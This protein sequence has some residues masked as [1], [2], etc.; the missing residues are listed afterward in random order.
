M[1]EQTNTMYTIHTFLGMDGMSDEGVVSYGDGL[2]TFQRSYRPLIGDIIYIGDRLLDIDAVEIEQIVCVGYDVFHA[3]C[4]EVK[5]DRKHGG[6]YG[7]RD[8]KGS[9]IAHLE[10]QIEAFP[11]RYKKTND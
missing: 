10:D 1:S 2:H 3:Y 5:A 7:V 4:T 11:N 9:L 8:N 6:Y